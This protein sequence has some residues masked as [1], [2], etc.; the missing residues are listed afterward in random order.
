MKLHKGGAW[1][2]FFFLNAVPII[3]PTAIRDVRNTVV[4]DIDTD[5][6]EKD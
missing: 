6:M 5:K 3:C 4:A 2:F 1:P